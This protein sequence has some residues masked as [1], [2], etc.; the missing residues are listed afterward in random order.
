MEFDR[1]WRILRTS[2]NAIG[3]RIHNVFMIFWKK[4][5]LNLPKS[6]TPTVAHGFRPILRSRSNRE[7]F[8]FATSPFLLRFKLFLNVSGKFSR[9]PEAHS[10]WEFIAFSWFFE[11]LSNKTST[12]YP[13]IFV[14]N[15]T[16]FE[17]PVILS[18]GNP[19]TP[20]FSQGIP[21]ILRILS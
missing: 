13:S 15:S 19:A 14:T 12:R 8:H 21:S 20:H 18:T 10:D 9:I 3:M 17:T 4:F 11:K 7:M 1:F 6:V 16:T 5:F 2:E